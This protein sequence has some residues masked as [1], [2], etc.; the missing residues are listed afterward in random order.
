MPKFSKQEVKKIEKDIITKG[1]ELF[2]TYGLKKTS[3]DDIVNACQ[4]G[5]GTFYRFFQSKE[6]LFFHI[7]EQEESFRLNLIDE[8][9]Q[10]KKKPKEAFKDFLIQSYEHIENN[11]FLQRVIEKED[12]E[13][14][15]RKLPK[16]KL[17]SH[18]HEDLKVVS[19]IVD[20]WKE[21]DILKEDDLEL[22]T[23]LLQSLFLLYKFKQELGEVFTKVFHKLIDCV[24]DGIFK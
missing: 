23:G 4:I 20:K 7:L 15:Y 3:I 5:K 6:L 11:P 24:I 19:I 1:K 21:K 22:L 14:L 13:Q 8:M 16:E 18:F 17:E 10:S 2:S 12:F 9:F